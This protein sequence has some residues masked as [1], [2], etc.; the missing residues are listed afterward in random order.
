MFGRHR[1]QWPNSAHL[2]PTGFSYGLSDIPQR[3]NSHEFISEVIDHQIGVHAPPPKSYIITKEDKEAIMEEDNMKKERYGIEKVVGKSFNQMD[4]NDMEKAIEGCPIEPIQDEKRFLEDESYIRAL[5]C[6]FPHVPT[7]LIVKCFFGKGT[8]CTI[9]NKT[10]KRIKELKINQQI[11]TK[12]ESLYE[13]ATFVGWSARD[14]YAGIN[15]ID[16]HKKK[17]GDKDNPGVVDEK[18]Y[19]EEKEMSTKKAA[20]P[21]SLPAKT[22]APEEPK[23]SPEKASSPTH[24]EEP[25]R[26]KTRGIVDI[27]LYGEKAEILRAIAELIEKY[28]GIEIHSIDM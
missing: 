22:P 27:S 1:T 18:Q 15:F 23:Q 7:S 28:A 3:D 2:F 20:T 11:T 5:F 10:Q 6:Y 8:G 14:P 24:S 4:E 9:F 17:H 25:Y 12:D 13:Q 19:K 21:V 26:A 16:E